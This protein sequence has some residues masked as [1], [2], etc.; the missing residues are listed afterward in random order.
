VY[1]LGRLVKQIRDDRS[2]TVLLVEHH[3]GMVMSISNNVVAFNFG[4]KIAEARRTPCAGIP[5]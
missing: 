1:E 4:K 5:S 2:V 3:M